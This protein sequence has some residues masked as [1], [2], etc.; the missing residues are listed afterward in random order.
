MYLHIC[1]M[2]I[3]YLYLLIYDHT[4]VYGLLGSNNIWNLRVQKNRTIGKIAFTVVQIIFLAM[5]ITNQKLS[6]DIFMIGSLLNIFMEHDPY[7][8][9]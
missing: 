3:F 1:I 2:C 9:T 6:F 7:L 5:P 8:I 4:L